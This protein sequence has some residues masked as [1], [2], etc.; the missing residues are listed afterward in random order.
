MR[1]EKEDFQHIVFY[2]DIQYTILYERRERFKMDEPGKRFMGSIKAIKSVLLCTFLFIPPLCL[3]GSSSGPVSAREA[4]GPAEALKPVHGAYPVFVDDM[5]FEFLTLAIRR[6]IAYLKGAGRN[7]IFQYGPHTFTCHEVL[8][9]QEAFLDILSRDLSPAQL[10]R[11]I[12][13]QFRVYRATGRTETRKVLFTAYY[14]PVF[15]ASLEPDHLFRYPI[16][17]KPDDLVHIDLSLFHEKFEGENLVGTIRGGRVLP[18]YTRGQIETGK[19]LSGRNLEIAWLKDPI[20]AYLLHIEGAGRLK[21][22]GGGTLSV[23]YAASNGR[24][25]RSFGRYL[26]ENGY[27]LPGQMSIE[28]I[29]KYLSD[30]PELLGPVLNHNESYVFFKETKEGA[31]GDSNIPLTFGRSLA[32]DARLFPMGALAFISCWKPSLDRR[33]NIAGWNEFSRFV[34]SQDTGTAIKGAGRADL[35]WGSGPEARAVAW[36]LK[37]DGDLYVLIRKGSPASRTEKRNP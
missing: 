3:F 17:G 18:Y 23:S 5:G 36:H 32:V 35:F 12:R 7:K 22:M 28:N 24:P 25:Y 27:L 15:E 21:L 31:L 26:L 2:L 29:R 13:R 4:L 19:I 16:Y 20:D 37:H 14:E 10:G 11:E 1:R 33:G 8:Q 6:N 9:S 34:L 30:H